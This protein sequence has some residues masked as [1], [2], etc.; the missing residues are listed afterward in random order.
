MKGSGFYPLLK[1]IEEV[2]GTQA[3]NHFIIRL[4]QEYETNYTPNPDVGLWLNKFGAELE[5]L[6]FKDFLEDAFQ[7][8][9][10]KNNITPKDSAKKPKSDATN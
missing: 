8:F 9:Y 7:I 3:R 2:W 4:I 6:N 5:K 10:Q 1:K